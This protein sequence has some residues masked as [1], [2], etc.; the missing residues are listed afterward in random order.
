M[1]PWLLAAALAVSDSELEE[2]RLELEAR[3]ATERA[4]FDA[5]N[6]E[7]Q[8]VL[9]LLDGLER[10]SR[11]S[12]E[13]V[14]ALERLRTLV[15]RQAA[16]AQ[17]ELDVA[18]TALVE[19][20]ARLR[21]K[22]M[23]LYRLE[24]R[25]NLGALLAAQDFA[26]LVWRQRALGALVAKDLEALEELAV[27]ARVHR[28]RQRRLERLERSAQAYLRAAGVERAVGQARRARLE[29][30]LASVSAEQ[31]RMSRVIAELEAAERE[32]ASMVQ[33]LAST[34]A[35]SGLRAHKG[36]LPRPTAGHVEVAFGKVVNPRFNTVTVQ[37]GLDIRA[38]AGT[39]V[40]SIGRGTV[41]Y[42]GWLKGY[43]QLVIVDHGGGYHSLYAHLAHSDVEVGVAVEEGEAIARVGDTGSLKGPYLYFEI[44][45]AGQAI[46]PQP[47]L[48]AE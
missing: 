30:L 38:P 3:L 26:A 23:T 39:E 44:R 21:P 5:L 17:V 16:E 42:A 2:E 20:R 18:R 12:A 47:W 8:G 14:G 33:E 31:D 7:R 11:E 32:L 10:A 15:R 6:S 37:K 24:R 22:L 40:V 27:T 25:D 9:T 1:T 13:R 36:R 29:E 46:D 4:A 43:G 41:V 34:G 19:Q 48:A 35:T 28:L 45:R